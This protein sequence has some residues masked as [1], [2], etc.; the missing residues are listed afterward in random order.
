LPRELSDENTALIAK[1]IK[2]I[3]NKQDIPR[4]FKES[5]IKILRKKPKSKEVDNVRPISL[6]NLLPRITAKIVNT[7]T[8]GLE[9][10]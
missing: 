1:V 5:L 9:S 6:T 4:E 8:S 3:I 7:H 10:I 2:E